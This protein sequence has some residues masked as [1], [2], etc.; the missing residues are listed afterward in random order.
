MTRKSGPLKHPPLLPL[1]VGGVTAKSLPFH[2]NNK[3]LIRLVRYTF[4][5]FAFKTI[6]KFSKCAHIAVS[7]FG[8][9]HLGL[10]VQILAS[11]DFFPYWGPPL[12]FTVPMWVDLTAS[13][14]PH[15][16]AAFALP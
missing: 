11:D 7:G 13:T 12:T 2:R 1:G 10:L 5:W 8:N 15:A 16:L 4:T 14:L 3:R 9:Q 6:T